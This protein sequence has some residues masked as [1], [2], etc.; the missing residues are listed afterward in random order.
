MENKNISAQLPATLK[1]GDTVITNKSIII[2]GLNKHF[3]MG[4]HVINPATSTHRNNTVFTAASGPSPPQFSFTKIQTEDVLRELQH[5]DS[6]KSA[7][8]D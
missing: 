8:L 4:D 5:L 1:L 6:Y 2:E 7:G 3:A